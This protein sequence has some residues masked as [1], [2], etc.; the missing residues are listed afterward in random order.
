[1]MT[2]ENTFKQQII[3]LEHLRLLKMFFYLKAGVTALFASLFIFHFIF[4]VILAVNPSMFGET[5]GSGEFPA[6]VFGIVIGLFICLGWLIAI[7]SAYAGK[8]IGQRKNR[9]LIYT[10]AA[11]NCLFIPYGTALGIFTFMVMNRPSVKTLFSAG[12][13]ASEMKG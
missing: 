8:C 11:I 10:M 9:G 7:L 12:G 13:D 4:M 5:K 1:M 3:D 6:L 2:E